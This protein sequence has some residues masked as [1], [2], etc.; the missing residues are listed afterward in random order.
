[1]L[2]MVEKGIRPGISG[3]INRYAKANQKYMKDCQ[4]LILFK[5]DHSFQEN[6]KYLNGALCCPQIL[7]LI[8][9]VMRRVHYFINQNITLKVVNFGG[10][11][12]GLLYN[13]GQT[14]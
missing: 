1:M 4:T 2:L 8:Q 11:A 12:E 7:S 6:Q 9:F 3:S 14:C 5:T 13:S 10:R